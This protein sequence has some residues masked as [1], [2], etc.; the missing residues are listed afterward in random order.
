M[1]R[2]IGIKRRGTRWLH[3]ATFP[4]RVLP[5]SVV[6]KVV[7]QEREV[8]VKRYRP[9]ARPRGRVLMEKPPV[10]G[11]ILE[12]SV[13]VGFR[14]PA[15]SRAVPEYHFLAGVVAQ[16]E[17]CH[18]E[19]DLFESTAS[20]ACSPSS[21][22]SSPDLCLRLLPA[23]GQSSTFVPLLSALPATSPAPL[24][25]GGG[26]G[27]GDG[28]ENWRGCGGRGGATQPADGPSDEVHQAIHVVKRRLLHC[29]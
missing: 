20:S 4:G 12:D 22:A 29:A 11:E 17:V 24:G 27:G 18:I 15:G 16:A 6:D 13:V 5:H 3:T 23:R 8:V 1:G 19:V 26:D 7:V 2:V 14:L 21:P 10:V 25:R 9:T 28:G